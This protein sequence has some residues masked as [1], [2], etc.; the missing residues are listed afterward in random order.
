MNDSQQGGDKMTIPYYK[1]GNPRDGFMKTLPTD[2]LM[3]FEDA[4][5]IRHLK[6]LMIRKRAALL[7][8]KETTKDD[9]ENLV[10]EYLNMVEILEKTSKQIYGE[11]TA[12]PAL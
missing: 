7:N 12:P 3:R 6:G 9:W 8:D 5:N 2:R 10:M 1:N 4:R 11:I